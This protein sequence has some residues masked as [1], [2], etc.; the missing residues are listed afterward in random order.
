L[1]GYA[2]TG[3]LKDGVPQRSVLDPLFFLLYIND[4]ADITQS[5]SWLFADDT[6]LLYSSNNI[7]EIEFIVNSYFSQNYSRSKEW[8]VD[9]NPTKPEC[10]VFS[11]D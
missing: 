11:T 8:L 3:N 7:Y 5:F 1:N 4:I 6:S 9:F 10:I 2:E